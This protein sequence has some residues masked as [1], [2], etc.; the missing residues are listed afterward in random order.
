MYAVNQNFQ[1]VQ[2][3][4]G[5]FTSG[6]AFG[7]QQQQRFQG[8]T[9]FDPCQAQQISAGGIQGAQQ[10]GQQFNGI[11][12]GNQ[13]GGGNRNSGNSGAPT[14]A[15]VDDFSQSN[16]GREM[17][18][19]IQQNGVGTAGFDV[20][21]GGVS[22]ALD[23]VINAAQRGQHFDA[24]NISQQDFQASQETGAVQ[25][26]IQV[27]QQMGIPV[28]VAAGNGGPNQ[29]NQL[30][31]GADFVAASRSADSGRGN[32]FGFG[33]TTSFAAANVASAV[34]KMHSQ[35][36]NVNQMRANFNNNGG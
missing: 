21:Q 33:G 35:G 22:R 31:V 36:L 8:P 15:V 11:V 1:G 10:L 14:V 23:G 12:G 34:A 29:T 30:A 16:H 20:K 5:N 3:V 27:L 7:V 18:S 6:G 2:Q 24:V 25:Q 4:Q 13:N 32:V 26:R 17:S 19:T 9:T 28:V